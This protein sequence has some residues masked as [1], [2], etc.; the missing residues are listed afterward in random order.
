CENVAAIVFSSLIN[1]K[2]PVFY[3]CIGAVGDM[4]K[5][6]SASAAPEMR[7][8]ES[9]GSQMARYY[10]IPSRGAAAS[11]D[12]IMM[13]FQAGAETA[14]GFYNSIRTGI[15]LITNMG[16][17]ANWMQASKAKLVLDAEIVDHVM[18]IVRPLEINEETVALDLVKNKGPRSTYLTEKHTLKN[19]KKNFYNPKVFRR[20]TYE[21]WD[22]EGRIA[23]DAYAEQRAKTLLDA[24]NAPDRDPSILKDLEKYVADKG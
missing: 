9:A 11:P 17:M 2:A 5:G 16:F 20:F 21:K 23:A 24:Y 1:P 4:K 14:M 13:D 10:K 18:R 19:Y 6:S 8:I 15:H 3:G 12:A 22:K 7:I